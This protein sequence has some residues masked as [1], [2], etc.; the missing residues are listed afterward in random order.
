[1]LKQNNYNYL[2][3]YK[4]LRIV[5]LKIFL[6]FFVDETVCA[7]CHKDFR[8]RLISSASLQASNFRWKL[9]L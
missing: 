4:I 3:Y 5:S 9:C 6:S 2:I 7:L 8:M 1:M